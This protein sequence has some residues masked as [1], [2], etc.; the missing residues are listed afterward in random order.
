MYQIVKD[1]VALALGCWL[2]WR[3]WKRLWGPRVVKDRRG[4]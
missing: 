3:L 4:G 2:G 1:G